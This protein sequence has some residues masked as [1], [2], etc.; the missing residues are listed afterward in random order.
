[1]RLLLPLLT[2]FAAAPQKPI[3]LVV[4]LAGGPG[5]TQAA[6][7]P[8]K[9]FLGQ[10]ETSAGLEAGTL[11]GK[12][13]PQKDAAMQFVKESAPGIFMIPPITFFE[14]EKAWGLT[15]IA[16]VAVKGSPAETL[17]LVV[18]KDAVANVAALNGK[19]VVTTL[20]ADPKFADLVVL[21][22]D[23]ALAKLVKLEYDRSP[24]A[25]MRK[26]RDGSAAAVLLDEAQYAGLEKLP[27]GA[28]LSLLAKTKAVPRS[29]I[30]VGKG[31][32]KATTQKLKDGLL[33]LGTSAEA[34]PTLEQFGVDGVVAAD[35][36]LLAAAR[37]RVGAKK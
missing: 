20:L 4:L 18:K 25:A 34:K 32:D 9:S 17:Y 1:M 2:L 26:V 16:Q 29:V 15:A 31:V 33:K 11:D 22:D 35:Q 27:F 37:K 3:Q 6:E 36:P 28:E 8:L 7:K 23:K 24:L 14:N 10:W 21:E 13:F 30:A 12:Y 5:D 19:T